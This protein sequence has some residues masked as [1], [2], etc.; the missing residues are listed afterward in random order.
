MKI[1]KS[2]LIV[3]L[4][5]FPIIK[6]VEEAIEIITASTLTKKNIRIFSIWDYLCMVNSGQWPDILK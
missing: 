5:L 2:V 3:V 6:P 1:R 4:L